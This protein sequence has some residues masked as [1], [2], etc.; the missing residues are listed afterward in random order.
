MT[1]EQF[2]YWLQGYFEIRGIGD[3][4]GVEAKEAKIIRD[5][6]RLVFKKVTP[7]RKVIDPDKLMERISKKKD[8]QELIDYTVDPWCATV[9]EIEEIVKNLDMSVS[10]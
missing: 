10:C 4:E 5:H 1:P 2:V 9:E 6:L 3:I 7:D 8:I